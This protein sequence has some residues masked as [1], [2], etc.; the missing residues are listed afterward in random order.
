MTVAVQEKMKGKIAWVKDSRTRHEYP[1]K[2]LVY[3]D[4]DPSPIDDKDEHFF[5]RTFTLNDDRVRFAIKRPTELEMVEIKSFAWYRRIELK[6][7]M[8]LIQK[9]FIT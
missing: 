5:V 8:Y 4:D 2:L 3:I 7:K 9:G 6:T 1:E